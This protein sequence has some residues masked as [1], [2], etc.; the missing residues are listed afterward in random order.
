MWSAAKAALEVCKDT[1]PI[2]D[3]ATLENWE[4]M[5]GLAKEYGVTLGRVC[6][7]PL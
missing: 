3:G 5:N 1:K 2:L 4:A 6:R 7:K